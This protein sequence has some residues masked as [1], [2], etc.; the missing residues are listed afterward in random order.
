MALSAAATVAACSTERPELA[1]LRYRRTPPNQIGTYERQID[2]DPTRGVFVLAMQN[3]TGF[4]VE[5]EA[6]LT[7]EGG[8]WLEDATTQLEDGW[9]APYEC[10]ECFAMESFRFRD[11]AGEIVIA[12]YNRGN[13]PLEVR[14]LAAYVDQLAAQT[15][16][17]PGGP[18]IAQCEL[19]GD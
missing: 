18:Y 17:C 14:P 5:Y 6:N 12:R 16:G 11:A 3:Q 4:V 9:S 13:P 8:Y 19:V 10:H 2:L 7:P 1:L 15:A